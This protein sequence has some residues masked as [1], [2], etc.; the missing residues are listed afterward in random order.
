MHKGLKSTLLT[1]AVALLGFKAM[2][3]APTISSMP[4]II[5]GDAETA[6]PANEYV[7][8]DAVDADTKVSDTDSTDGQIIWSYTNPGGNYRIN[9]AT[10]NT[11]D[12]VNP[13][14]GSRINVV[15]TDPKQVDNNPRTFTFRNIVHSPIGGS[16][17]QATTS[18]GQ[19]VTVVASDGS[20]AS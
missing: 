7:F 16:Y 19:V 13:A 5:I 8:P 3:T 1:V 14:A 10:P 4:D 6:T 18:E 12:L 15:D 11:G 20:T 2:A 9:N 17:T